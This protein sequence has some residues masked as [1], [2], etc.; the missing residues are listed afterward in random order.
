MQ[1]AIISKKQPLR[2]RIH[3]F[4]ATVDKVIGVDE[5]FLFG[6]TAKGKRRKT[7]DVD[8]IV[9]SKYFNNIPH[10]ERPGILENLWT[11]SEELESLTYAPDEFEQVKSRLLMQE[12]LSYAIDLTPSKAKKVKHKQ[13]IT[14][15]VE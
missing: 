2:E 10:H 1:R 9:V 5:A 15:K 12:I 14:L 3:K 11:Y 7:S 6:S 4:I 8:I 13:R